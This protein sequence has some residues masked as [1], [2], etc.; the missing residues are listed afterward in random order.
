MFPDL[1]G[2]YRTRFFIYWTRDGYRSTGFYNLNC[3]GFVHTN[4]NIALG[5]TIERIST[6]HGPQYELPF[7]IWKWLKVFI[8][9]EQDSFTLIG[10]CRAFIF[11]DLADSASMSR[12]GGEVVNNVIIGQHTAAEMGCGHFPEEKFER[13]S[14]FKNLLTIDESNNLV[15][16]EDIITRVDNANCYDVEY[17]PSAHLGDM[18]FYG[19]PGKNDNCP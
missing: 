2:D 16:P 15:I 4:K 13:S 18:L 19:G 3:R 14:H 12:W 6:Y 10:Y 8:I 7:F 5:T 11:T 9:L 1:Y 17:G